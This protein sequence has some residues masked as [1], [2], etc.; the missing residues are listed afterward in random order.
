LGEKPEMSS[1]DDDGTYYETLGLPPDATLKQVK[2]RFR[3]L[4]D[5]YLKILEQSRKGGSGAPSHHGSAGDNALHVTQ[6][7]KADSGPP[8]SSQETRTEPM[9]AL[10]EKLA[11][12]KIDKAQF[13]KLARERY[14]YLENKPFSELSDSEFEERLNGFEG[15]KLS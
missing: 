2:A 15:L 1:T 6:Q 12:G 8:S 14:D 7:P 4:N 9:T 5:A 11:K 13:E 3:E 10:R